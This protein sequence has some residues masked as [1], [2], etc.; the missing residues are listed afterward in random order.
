MGQGYGCVARYNLVK[1]FGTQ[2]AVDDVSL[3][4]SEQSVYGFLGANG[5]GKTTVL[6]LV[7]GLLRPDAG[8]IELFGE[9]VRW[10]HRPQAA[11]GALV[12]NPLLYSHLTGQE[13]LDLTRRILALPRSEI[14]RVLR[15]VDLFGVKRQKVGGYS[16]GMRQRLALARAL[17]G[18]P[19]LLILDEPTNGLDPDGISAMREL[20]RSLPAQADVTLLIS[21]HL[22]SEVQQIA[23]HVGLMHHGRLLIEDRLDRLIGDDGATLVETFDTMAAAELLSRAGW[24][25]QADGPRLR[26]ECKAP[27]FPADPDKIARLL[28]ESGQQ[29]IHLARG[30]PSLEQVYHREIARVAA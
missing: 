28:V 17:L 7:L 22:L 25:V 10:G 4:V 18:R 15:L 23:T 1:A 29:L 3:T 16:L 2:R 8:R 20:L 5:A 14:D 21:S 12:E 27:G 19:R 11:I 6:R 13:T 24:R 26:V 30:R 9:Q